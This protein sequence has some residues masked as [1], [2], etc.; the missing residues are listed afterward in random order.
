MV[1]LGSNPVDQ[2]LLLVRVLAREIVSRITFT[3]WPFR[4]EEG[5]E[6]LITS[7]HC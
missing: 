1:G 5:A 7:N 6:N 3:L 2:T 4:G